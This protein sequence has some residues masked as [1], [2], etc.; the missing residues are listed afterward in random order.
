MAKTQVKQQTLS[1]SQLE[2]NH[3]ITVQPL[4]TESLWV[5]LFVKE[6][7]EGHFAFFRYS[8]FSNVPKDASHLLSFSW[9]GHRLRAVCMSG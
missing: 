1:S 3:P 5:D 2:H 8:L 4:S 6:L 7:S 9:S